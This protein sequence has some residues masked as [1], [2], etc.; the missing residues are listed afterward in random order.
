MVALLLVS[1]LTSQS[2]WWDEG[3][4]LHLASLPWGDIVK[5][6][7]SNIH[8]PLYFFLLKGWTSWAGDSPFAARYLSVLPTVLLPAAVYRFCRKRWGHRV[9]RITAF[10]IALSPPF[11]IYGQEIRAYAFLPLFWILVLDLSWPETVPGD[12]RPRAV[13]L[14]VLEA[15]FVLFHYAGFVALAV[16]DLLLFA[17]SLRSKSKA[18]AHL[19]RRIGWTS[20]IGAGLLLVPWG[21]VIAQAGFSGVGEQAGLSNALTDPVSGRFVVTLLAAFHGLGLPQALLDPTLMRPLVLVG[22][23]IFGGLGV[24]LW[25][26]DCRRSDLRM[27]AIWLLPLGVAPF[28]WSL[29]PQAHPRYLLPFVL[30][31]WLVLGS[32]IGRTDIIRL[33]RGFILAST[34]VMAILGFW[35]YVNNPVYARSDVRSVA[36]YLR[37]H[38]RVDDVVLVPHTDWSLPQYDLGNVEFVMVPDPSDDAKVFETLRRA[39]HPGKYVYLLDYERGALD[40]RNQVRAYLAASGRLIARRRF[41]GVFLETYELTRSLKPLLCEDVEGCLVDQT[42]CLKGAAVSE[43]PISGGAVGSRLCWTGSTSHP[44]SA[45]MRLYAPSGALVSSLDEQLVD[46]HVQP[47]ELWGSGTTS[48]YHVVPVPVGAPPQSHR[49][50]LGVY[51]TGSPDAVTAWSTE[52]GAAPSISLS[53]VVPA[54]E[55]WNERSLYGLS[56][57]PTE[58]SA[59]FGSGVRLVGASVDRQELYAGQPFFAT[60]HWS[61]AE[62]ISSPVDA[63]LV[64]TQHSQIK[65]RIPVGAGLERLPPGRPL[66]EQ[67]KLRVP[68]EIE[69]GDAAVEL[70]FDGETVT[71]SG[72]HVQSGDRMF[73]PPPV[74]SKTRAELP[75]VGMLVGFDRTPDGPIRSGH[76]LTLTLVWKA[77]GE[78]P[79]ADYTVFTHLVSSSGEIVAQHDGKPHHGTRPTPS[80]LDGE[81]I[82]DVHVL[83]WEDPYQGPATL[84]VGMY[85]AESGQRVQWSTD[86]DF[87]VLSDEINVLRSD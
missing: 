81:Y 82:T 31:G 25:Q 11:L 2:L 33:L 60:I 76:P 7:A 86:G 17:G 6:R 13:A 85:E 37:S 70:V 26:T 67:V 80:W 53:T 4:S 22:A 69:A 61:L 43:S 45:A 62:S 14:A 28:I 83:R 1:S 35:A 5:N 49:L 66:V 78:S 36:S 23:G 71:V 15:I 58:P 20:T 51:K 73:T 9:G 52:I 84:R 24:L 8:P 50:A 64:L 46:R 19:L 75:Q 40:P 59:Q 65:A 12:W 18:Q 57:G 30:S 48:T 72:I 55:P 39:T 63:S 42:L 10:L 38:A 44:L 21:V 34:L 29:S 41:H 68:A 54:L 79:D 3:I 74:S 56:D 77:T 87:F 32:L 47:T 27:L 16:A